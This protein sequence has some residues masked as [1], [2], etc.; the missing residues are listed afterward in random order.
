MR[1]ADRGTAP[2]FPCLELLRAGWA[3]GRAVLVLPW[4]VEY[5]RMMRWD[6]ISARTRY[7]Q[8]RYGRR[9]CILRLDVLRWSSLIEPDHQTTPPTQ[10][11]V[12]A[13]RAVYWRLAAETD[14]TEVSSPT[15][16]APA[17]GEEPPDDGRAGNALFLSF[18]LEQLFEDL[19]VERA[20][21][22]PPESA[23]LTGKRGD[24]SSS[25]LC[26]LYRA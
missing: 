8:V 26:R 20:G 4:V 11:I 9:A 6:P 22:P 10:E 13:L 24:G 2:F 12:S 17:Q 25:W 18:E 5:L 14:A 21:P 1:A 3:T 15:P 23:L 7:Y 16:P 19:A